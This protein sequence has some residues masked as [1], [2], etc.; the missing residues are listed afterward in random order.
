MIF[1]STFEGPV[2]A[3]ARALHLYGLPNASVFTHTAADPLPA[4]VT[5][6]LD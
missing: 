2:P 4:H 5:I 3:G 6:D 1:N